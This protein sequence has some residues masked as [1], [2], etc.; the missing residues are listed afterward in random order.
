[1]DFPK[2]PKFPSMQVQVPAR[3]QQSDGALTSNEKE[4]RDG[5]LTSNEASF[6]LDSTLSKK[7]RSD[8]SIL[9]FIESFIRCKN[10]AEAS[11]E[12]GVKPS[13]GYQYRHR[14]DISAAIQKLIDRSAIKFGFDASEIV[15]RVKE[16]VDFDPIQMQN[17]DGSFKSNL[18]DIEP[19]A[20]R[21][22]KKLKV[23]NL[24]AE[25][26]DINGIKT[27]IIIGEVI[28]YEFYDKLKAGELVGREKDLFKNKSVVEHGVTKDMA[29]IL[30]EAARRG[31]SV[32]KNFKPSR[33][34][35]THIVET[36]EETDDGDI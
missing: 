5:S 6:I 7:H 23:K 1:M 12:A 2:P 25:Q 24:W 4:T 29:N 16:V 3:Q 19:A 15:E 18:K 35:E 14:S 21:C 13:V 27:K 31:E 34:I 10:I 30:L 36:S 28:E 17:A 8:P 11:A 22:L 20:R 9:A 26:E 32:E 33:V